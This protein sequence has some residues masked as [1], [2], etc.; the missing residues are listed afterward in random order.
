MEK[1]CGVGGFV[2]HIHVNPQ[3]IEVLKEDYMDNPYFAEILAN[4][5]EPEVRYKTFFKTPNNIILFDDP[6]G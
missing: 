6:S 3:E 1:I 2:T 4:L 5:M